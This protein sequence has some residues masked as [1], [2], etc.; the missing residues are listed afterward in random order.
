MT[1]S[2]F[3]YFVERYYYSDAL[4]SYFRHNNLMSIAFNRI[5]WK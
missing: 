4:I 1:D 3:R 2:D 5:K